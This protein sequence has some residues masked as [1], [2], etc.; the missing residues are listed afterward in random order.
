[1]MATSS[2]AA[3]AN[4]LSWFIRLAFEW[5][6]DRS[7]LLYRCASLRG[8]QLP[9]RMGSDYFGAAGHEPQALDGGVHL[10]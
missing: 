6:E 3:L 7:S 10:S 8:L 4:S 9:H 5:Q 1:M 2:L